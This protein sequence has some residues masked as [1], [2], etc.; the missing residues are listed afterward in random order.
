MAG[1][2]VACR[3]RSSGGD[4]GFISLIKIIFGCWAIINFFLFFFFGSLIA[5]NHFDEEM[6]Q[7]LSVCFLLTF[8]IVSLVVFCFSL[9]VS[10]VSAPT[11]R[12]VGLSFFMMTYIFPLLLFWR[13]IFVLLT[14]D[15][16]LCCEY[17]F[18][19]CRRAV[20]PLLVGNFL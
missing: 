8:L 2:G 10:L 3:G 15:F 18:V 19:L 6:L 12:S 17:L 1:V 7:V 5:W 14:G 16:C 20:I 9:S 11:R 4:N 13:V